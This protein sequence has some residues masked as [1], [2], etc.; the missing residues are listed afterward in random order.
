MGQPQRVAELLCLI[1][2]AVNRPGLA[3][4]EIR[5]QGNPRTHFTM[6]LAARRLQQVGS[7]PSPFVNSSF[8]IWSLCGALRSAVLVA[9]PPPLCQGP[10]LCCLR[11]D[12]ALPRRAT[13]LRADPRVPPITPLLQSCHAGLLA[14]ALAL[15]LLSGAA[16]Q[17]SVTVQ[18][19]CSVP[20]DFTVI[21]Q[22]P[23]SSDYFSVSRRAGRVRVQHLWTCAGAACGL[24]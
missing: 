20:V 10:C 4:T 13:A 1:R 3:A 23:A 7:G 18:N 16:A 6:S 5:V 17:S 11:G 9:P 21:F 15:A 24:C 22:V 12:G 19:S 8:A 2:T 14:A